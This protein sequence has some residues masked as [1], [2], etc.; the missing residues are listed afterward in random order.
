VLEWLNVNCVAE[1]L[2][3]YF[4][5]DSWASTNWIMFL[6]I[7]TTAVSFVGAFIPILI[8]P[9]SNKRIRM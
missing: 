3:S 7:L 9:V 1:T 8:K 5:R 4:F 2:Q 6:L